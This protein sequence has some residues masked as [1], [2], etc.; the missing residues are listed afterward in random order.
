MLPP[1]L[2]P[3]AKTGISARFLCLFHSIN[4][5]CSALL[6]PSSKLMLKKRFLPPN[7]RSSSNT[8]VFLLLK[9][10]SFAKLDL[11]TRLCR[12]QPCRSSPFWSISLRLD[13]AFSAVLCSI[14]FNQRLQAC[15]LQYF[16]SSKCNYITWS[17]LRFHC[18]CAGCE[19]PR[20]H[21]LDQARA[22][23]KRKHETTDVWYIRS[24]FAVLVVT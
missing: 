7:L 8:L 20:C 9:M 11:R 2:L 17:I 14:F 12:C 10:P 4:L 16:L 5:I 3:S 24:L 18:L 6:A 22:R 15:E 21:V 19:T 1:R 13:C 23:R